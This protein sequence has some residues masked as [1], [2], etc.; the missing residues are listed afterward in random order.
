V[1]ALLIALALGSAS[2]AGEL[3]PAARVADPRDRVWVGMPLSQ[4][5]RVVAE[6]PALI[7]IWNKDGIFSDYYPRTK[8]VV[9]YR[10]GK[11]VRIRK[12]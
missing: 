2:D 1:Q 11:V 5:C 9:F 3:H 7:A 8:L 12:W 4:V 10:N 6:Q